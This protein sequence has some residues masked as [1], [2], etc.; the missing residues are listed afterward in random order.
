MSAPLSNPAG[1]SGPAGVSAV[2]T[3]RMQLRNDIESALTQLLA[4]QNLLIANGTFTQAQINTAISGASG[5]RTATRKAAM[6]TALG[7]GITLT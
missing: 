5:I 1:V 7:T 4:L 6:Q 2:G 3:A